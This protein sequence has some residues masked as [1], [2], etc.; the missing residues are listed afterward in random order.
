MSQ[1]GSS[2]AKSIVTTDTSELINKANSIVAACT[3]PNCNVS[4]S[5]RNTIPSDL[6]VNK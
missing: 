5:T 3:G 2:T 4:E 6:E 1:I